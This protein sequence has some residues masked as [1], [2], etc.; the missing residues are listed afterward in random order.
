MWT[1]CIVKTPEKNGYLSVPGLEPRA[2]IVRRCALP[3]ELRSLPSF[4][5]D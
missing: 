3:T 5:N 4:T 2:G 1:L